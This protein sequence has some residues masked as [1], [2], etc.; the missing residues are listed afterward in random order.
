MDKTYTFDTTIDKSKMSAILFL[1]HSSRITQYGNRCY[2]KI[3]QVIAPLPVGYNVYVVSDHFIRTSDHFIR[4]SRTAFLQKH[5]RQQLVEKPKGRQQEHP[6]FLQSIITCLLRPAGDDLHNADG[7]V[8][9]SSGIFIKY[10]LVSCTRFPNVDGTVPVTRIVSICKCVSWFRLPNVDGIVPVNLLRSKFNS[11]RFTRFPRVDGIVPV[12]ILE[13]TLKEVS[14]V[15]NPISLGILLKPFITTLLPNDVTFG[16][17]SKSIIL[18]NLHASA[19]CCV[20]GF[21]GVA[22]NKS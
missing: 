22:F 3:L 7:I 16:Q 13:Q 17:K 1:H 10:K 11:L 20:E 15:R 14:C 18:M 12:N 5:Q 9:C 6:I 2:Q 4:T 21:S 19:S 8:P